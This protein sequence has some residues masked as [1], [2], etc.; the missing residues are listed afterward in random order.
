MIKNQKEML[1]LSASFNFISSHL[2]KNQIPNNFSLNFVPIVVMNGPT[3]YSHHDSLY[4][5]S[6]IVLRNVYAT[7]FGVGGKWE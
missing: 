3:A 5:Y 6:N 1:K 4:E 2:I 7:D